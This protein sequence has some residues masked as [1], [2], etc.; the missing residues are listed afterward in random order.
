MVYYSYN[1]QS[2]V[3]ISSEAVR[4]FSTCILILVINHYYSKYQAKIT[5]ETRNILI[6]A[7]P[8]LTPVAHALRNT[9]PAIYTLWHFR[10]KV[11]SNNN[12]IVP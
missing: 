9:F 8:L 6:E 11:Y 2:N 10:S 3:R 7:T 4:S 5:S 12:A 1:K